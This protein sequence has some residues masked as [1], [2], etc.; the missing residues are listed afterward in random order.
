MRA[1]YNSR[2]ILDVDNVELLKVKYQHWTSFY[3]CRDELNISYWRAEYQ[4]L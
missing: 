1:L 4:D 2:F 3:A